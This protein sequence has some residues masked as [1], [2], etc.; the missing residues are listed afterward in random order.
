M[1]NNPNGSHWSAR[2]PMSI[3]DEGLNA[4]GKPDPTSLD[5]RWL[6]R[7]ESFL[8]ING[9]NPRHHAMA[10]DLREYLYETCEHRWLEY[11]A[12]A[13]I[14]AHGQ[15]QWCNDVQWHDE[16]TEAVTV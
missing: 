15:C 10:A 6:W 3:L 4:H 16:G 7:L 8:A 2:A 1:L 11:E 5:R 14:P 13:D 12:E 9:T